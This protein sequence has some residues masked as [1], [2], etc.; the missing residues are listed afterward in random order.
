MNLA[1]GPMGMS[2]TIVRALSVWCESKPGMAIWV[3][4]HFLVKI[5]SVAGL[6]SQF[7]W[8]VQQCWFSQVTDSTVF[9]QVLMDYIFVSTKTLAFQSKDTYKK[10]LKSKCNM[11]VSATNHRCLQ[12][13]TYDVLCSQGWQRRQRKLG[14]PR[15]P[16]LGSGVPRGK[17]NPVM[18]SRHS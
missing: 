6:K 16:L 3:Y 8:L 10:D 12:Y 4:C 15:G 18:F 7:W 17:T 1:M 2:W 5:R 14:P 9:W 11:F 13:R